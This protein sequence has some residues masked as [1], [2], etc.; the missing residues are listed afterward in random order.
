MYVGTYT[1]TWYIYTLNELG[2]ALLKDFKIIVLKNYNPFGLVFNFVYWTLIV[3]KN[4][5]NLLYFF[6]Y[7]FISFFYRYSL[8]SN[9][10]DCN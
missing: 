4:I 5:A 2:K 6:I 1:Y 10:I 9:S 7:L 8:F 3:F